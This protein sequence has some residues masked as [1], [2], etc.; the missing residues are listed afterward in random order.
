MA[1]KTY[2]KQ[3]IMSDPQKIKNT[4]REIKILSKLNHPN[5]IKL[6]S[7]AETYNHLHLI[8]EFTSELSLADLVKQQKEKKISEK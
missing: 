4:Q 8:M 3:K 5:I 2:D 6:R 7:C 1:I